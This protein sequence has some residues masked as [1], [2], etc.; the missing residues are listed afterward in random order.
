MTKRILTI[1]AVALTLSLLT[2]CSNDD[3]NV[4]DPV[5]GDT[6]VLLIQSDYGKTSTGT[7]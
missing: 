6:N 5:V 3:D 7:M 4:G 1:F 2:A